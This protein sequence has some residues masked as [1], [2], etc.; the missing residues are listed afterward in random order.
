M[1]RVPA[2]SAAALVAALIAAS[3]S[4]AATAPAAGP[5]PASTTTLPVPTRARYPVAYR[6]ETL[7]DASRPTPAN[8]SAPAKPTRTLSTIVYY[9]TD[10]AL[11]SE[12]AAEAPARRGPWPLVV[13]AHGLD[14]FGSA[15]QG[16]LMG[17]ASAGYV[18]A[19]PTFPLSSLTAPGGATI[20]DVVNQP[21]DVSFV[22]GQLL[23]EGAA[24]SGP[25]SGA[26][27]PRRVAVAGH[28]LGAITVLGLL[29]SCCHDPRID[30]AIILAGL[31]LSFGSGQ[32]FFPPGEAPIP[33]LFEQGTRDRLIGYRYDHQAYAAA[34]S[35]KYFVTLEGADHIGPYLDMSSAAGRVVLATTTDFLDQ[36]VTRAPAAEH[37][38]VQD[39]TVSGVAHVESSIT[40]SR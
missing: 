26:V 29:N 6:S 2:R 40:P 21:A 7:M 14:G 18:V 13:F 10:G 12:P 37:G 31:E 22:L 4:H 39:G 24:S 9:P 38:L 34:P 16:L 15:Y 23:R 1:G 32:R 5:A 19:A 27:D 33:V 25:L 8:G 30:A 11:G 28:S 3:C 35:P 20:A 36:Y 17:W